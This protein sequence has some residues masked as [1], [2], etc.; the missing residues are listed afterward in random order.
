MNNCVPSPNLHRFRHTATRFQKLIAYNHGTELYFDIPVSQG[1]P[2]NFKFRNHT[3][4]HR[5]DSAF[6][7]KPHNLHYKPCNLALATLSQYTC[8][9]QA[10]DSI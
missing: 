7:C 6:Q 10:T 3:S 4:K 5:H 9:R 8:Y 2:S 1:I